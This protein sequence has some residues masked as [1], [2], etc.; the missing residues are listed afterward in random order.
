MIPFKTKGKVY[1]QTYAVVPFKYGVSP[2]GKVSFNF[3]CNLNDYE[4]P[5]TTRYSEPVAGSDTCNKT[6]SIRHFCQVYI[7]PEG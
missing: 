1:S 7:E 3:D 6:F 4:M 2:P 5:P